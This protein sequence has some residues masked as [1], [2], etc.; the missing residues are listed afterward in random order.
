MKQFYSLFVNDEFAY[1]LLLQ[2]EKKGLFVTESEV[3]KLSDLTTHINPKYEVFIC[4]T[5]DYSHEKIIDIPNAIKNAKTINNYILHTL[6]SQDNKRDYLFKYSRLS[7]TK[8]GNNSYKVYNIDEAQYEQKLKTIPQYQNITN[9]TIEKFSLLAVSQKCI[10]AST[11]ISIYTYEKNS[12]IVAVHNGSLLFYRSSSI[13]AITPETVIMDMT[14]EINQTISYI[15]QQ[16]RDLKFSVIAL[17]GMLA[18]DDQIPQQLMLFNDIPVAV[19]YPN[20]LINGLSAE[21]GQSYLLAIGA[22]Y[23]PKEFQFFPKTL[24]GI[25]QYNLFSKF[26]MFAS[27]FIF[28]I[29]SYFTFNAY[30]SYNESLDRYKHLTRQLNSLMKNT[31]LLNTP[32]LT[33]SL[34]H[35]QVAQENLQYK[36]A[37]III[38]FKPLINLIKPD[39]WKWENGQN[40]ILLR[41]NF[42][43]SFNKLEKLYAFEK[44]FNKIINDINSSYPLTN[45]PEIDYKTLK[46]KTKLSLPAIQKETTSADMLP[47]VQ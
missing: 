33:R 7:Q 28:C 24:L 3:V 43:K 11:Y 27:I 23:V 39:S 12:L 6:K 15:E 22:S 35:L 47:E 29:V 31:K 13:N 25:K 1:I 19:L 46:F 40:G 44:K 5:Q 32:I 21:E 42:Q 30:N 41:A 26:L 36:P 14:A 17:S 10:D 18:L 2:K 20:T 45:T 9:A 37:D 16:N 38:T 34:L 8:E 4:S